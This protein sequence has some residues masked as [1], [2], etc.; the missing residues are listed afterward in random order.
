MATVTAPRG[1]P[2]LVRAYH[3]LQ[4]RRHLV[5]H[6][7][8]DDLIRWN[9]RYQPFAATVA[10]FLAVA[11][12]T[13]IVRYN[14]V[15]GLSYYD[16]ASREFVRRF[17]S[18]PDGPATPP[19]QPPA[20]NGGRRSPLVTSA[21]VLEQQLMAARS[22]E[23]RT[24]V[25][26]LAVA[27]R[28]MNQNERP[29]VVIVESADLLVGAPSH[30]SNDHVTQVAYVRR[31]LAAD[32][33]TPGGSPKYH[34]TMIFV[35]RELSA[36]PSWLHRDNPN[37][38]AVLADRPAIAERAAFLREDVAGY[39]GGD[40]M[41]PDARAEA[42]TTLASLTDGM[43]IVDIGALRVTSQV[44]RIPPTM[45]RRLV[46]R[47]RFGLRDDPW[48]QLD[49]GKIKD[50]EALL[51]KR[52]IG[53]LPAVR[54]VTDVLVNARVGLDF[55]SA[56][57]QTGTRPKGVFFFVGPTGVGKTELAKALAEL[58]FD[59]ESALRRFD[60][61]EYSQEH[62]SERLTGAPPGYV[63]HEH[64]GTLT[65]WVLERP[66]SVLLFD[67][68][69]K[70]HEKIMDKFLQLIDDGR[71]TD[72][73]GRT[74]Y[75]SHS[76]VIFTSNIGVGDLRRTFTDP[77]MSYEAVREHF[78]Q[79]VT[80][81]FATRLHRPELLGR[82]G[83]GVVVFD[84]L[85]ENVIMDITAKFLD[86]IAMA[87]RARGYDLVFDRTAIGRAVVDEIVR[88][89]AALG[90]RQIRSPLLERWVRVP[91]NRWI[92]EHQPAPGT[93]ILVHRRGEGSPPF[94]VDALSAGESP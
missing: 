27:L 78:S 63:G 83:T 14:L 17:L 50:A 2:W 51:S 86:Q 28:L 11:G 8:V 39:F 65:N 9:D 30:F 67:E 54:A 22:A 21:D 23:P 29:C 10:D 52:V 42:T 40:T 34:N 64:G 94:A 74:A 87:A 6:G 41:T 55:V 92:L 20:N 49:I 71:L 32:P 36:L 46:A 57:Q 56:G 68:I 89:G 93:R 81:H 3:E 16:D 59:D 1:A 38:V 33:V 25:D 37:V 4:R 91:L 48:E 45:P 31:L 7:N 66:F 84:L 61:S 62:T 18:D 13:V 82:L 26:V 90:A 43:T 53:Q 15:E 79:A 75:F 12:F 80:E 73:Q 85:R 35:A 88:S 19:R 47:H 72:G 5:V 70:A 77:A 44:A 58:V 60:M 69:E 76:I 24:A